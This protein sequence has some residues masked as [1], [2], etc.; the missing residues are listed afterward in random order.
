MAD[1][2]DLTEVTTPKE[3]SDE[4]CTAVL[5]RLTRKLA[6]FRNQAEMYATAESWAVHNTD[7]SQTQRD[8]VFA[9]DAWSQDTLK[10]VWL[11]CREPGKGQDPPQLDPYSDTST[12]GLPPLRPSEQLVPLLNTV[13]LLHVTADKEYSSRTRTF[14][15]SIAP[16]DEK[17]VARTLKNPTRA[18]EEAEKKTNAAREEH[19]R[20]SRIMR[21][22]GIGA[23]AIAGGTIIGLTGGLAAPAIGAGVSSIL[24]WMGVGGTAVGVLATGLAGSSVVCGAVFGAYGSKESARVIS[25]Y[26]RDVQDLAIKP[27][28][29]PR[30]TMAARLCV[31]GWL[32]KTEDVTAPWT[33]FKGDDTFALQ[34]EVEAL[35]KLSKAL[36][37]LM[38]TQALQYI[39]GQII[40]RTVLAGL[41]SALSP[42]AWTKAA[43]IIDNPWVTASNLAERTG[44]VLGDLLAQRVLGSRPITLVGYS[45][46]SLV[47]FEALQYLASLPP[48]Q[49]LGLIQD[50]Y[51]FGSPISTSAAQ[52]AAVR[53]V[54]SG[55]VVNGYGKNDYV[56]AVLARASGMSWRVAG[57]APVEL[58]G[59]ENVACDEVDGHLKWRGMIG[60][61]L[62][63]CSAYVVDQ[64]EVKKQLEDKAAK[65]SE[66]T[67]MDEKEAEEAVQAGPGTD[68]ESG[69][70]SSKPTAS[71][72]V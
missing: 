10:N 7:S 27:V 26:T 16:V 34:W 48:A 64:A 25:Q 40:R 17:S 56:L 28:H 47:I 62:A 52:W 69:V 67:D 5:E 65:I 49:T 21:Y 55:R 6:G 15:F 35:E 63:K 29:E 8:F 24:G 12:A 50:V 23:G 1:K 18:I 38:K 2:I 58:Q 54:V 39:K 46:G 70:D 4:Q 9:L 37:D 36:Y 53:R 59:V 51:L 42:T 31:T 3:L 32:D 71:A 45:L 20:R 22:A 44:K 13:L 72:S 60:Q 11:A 43:K 57:I 41:W 66:E 61:C 33:V 14:L 19:S 68:S 30:E